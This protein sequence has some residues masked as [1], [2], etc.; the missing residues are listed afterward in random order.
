MA[1]EWT[2]DLATGVD[3]VDEQ[4]KE[5]FSRINTLLEACKR[6]EGSA[7]V[8]GTLGFLTQYV[9]EHF[10]SEEALMRRAAYSG[11]AEHAALHREFKRQVETFAS[12][13]ALRGV[14]MTTVVTINRMIVG[15]LNDH[16]R[17]VDRAMAQAIRKQAPHV[18]TDHS[19]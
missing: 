2:K 19:Q 1:I 7:H 12:D 13:L 17:T 16:I 5:L 6:G 10:D 4:H 11:Y 18:L 15:W 9:I 14:T 3:S 8:V